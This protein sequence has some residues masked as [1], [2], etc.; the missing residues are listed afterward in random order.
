MQKRPVGSSSAATSTLK[1]QLIHSVATVPLVHALGPVGADVLPNER[2]GCGGKALDGHKGKGIQLVGAVEARHKRRT[3]AVDE[4][5]H[6]HDAEAEQR[7]LDAGGHAQLD[8]L[9]EKRFVELEAER[10]DVD[11]GIFLLM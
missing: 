4:P 5:L 11:L 3:V 7:L 8:D 2:G 10:M 1:P 9:A 6:G